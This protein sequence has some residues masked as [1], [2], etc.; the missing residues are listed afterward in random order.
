MTPRTR[1][2]LAICTALTLPLGLAACGGHADSS[3]TTSPPTKSP[4]DRSDRVAGD[5][6]DVEPGVVEVVAVDFRFENL[7]GSVAAGTRLTLRNDAVG[8]LHELVAFRLADEETRSVEQ[9]LALAPEDMQAALGEPAT[10][11]LA[12]PASEQIAVPI[13]DGTLDEPG[14]YAILCLIP[15]GADADEYLAAAATSGG[16]PDVAGGPPHIAHGMY[17]ELTAL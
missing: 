2:L 13:G 15:T 5:Q 6:S 4:G 16:P 8:E 17:A 1:N 11:I 7:P 12:P 10:V 3:T 9:I 14:R